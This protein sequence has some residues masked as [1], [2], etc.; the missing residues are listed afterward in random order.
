MD[1]AEMLLPVG[2]RYQEVMMMKKND[3]DRTDESRR[4][5]GSLV[6][7][8]M[9]EGQRWNWMMEE[10]ELDVVIENHCRCQE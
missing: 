9:T 8:E 1:G 3:D 5:H 2:D 6:V 4:A 7:K 10:N